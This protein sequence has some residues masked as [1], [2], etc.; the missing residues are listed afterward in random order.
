[1]FEVWGSQVLVM[2]DERSRVLLASIMQDIAD[3]SLFIGPVFSLFHYPY[4]LLFPILILNEISIKFI[5][6]ILV[7]EDKWQNNLYLSL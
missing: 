1:M 3:A 7:G 5:S 6:S 4:S 2:L